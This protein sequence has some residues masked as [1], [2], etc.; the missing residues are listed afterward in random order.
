M[1]WVVEPPL[2]C[3]PAA[4]LVARLSGARAW[5]HVQ[6]FEVDAAF[7][8][9]LLSS[10]G[11]Y[12]L[13]A[14]IERCL[15]SRFD[16]VSTISDK[17]LERLSRKGVGKGILFPN[18]VD[19]DQIFPMQDVGSLRR[20]LGVHDHAVVAL[21]AGNMGRKQGLEIVVEAARLLA[22]RADL[23]FIL[24]GE[25]AA[26]AE[27]VRLADGMANVTFLPLQPVERLND[28]LNMADIHLLPQDNSASDLVMPS[29]LTG[30]LASGRP[31]VA[32]AAPG[33]QIA[34]VVQRCGKVV[35][36]GDARAFADAIIALAGSGEEA[37]RL[38]AAGRAYAVKM[39]GREAVLYRFESM[40][41]ALTATGRADD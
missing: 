5:L 17:M 41:H 10:R 1:V 38:G 21:Y 3:A 2:F 8:L 31:V 25:G 30:M 18:W 23:R 14:G 33:T 7:E 6:D 34:E 36:P 16:S 35:P 11:L 27:L 40:L 22:D 39:W 20:E 28:L 26:K 24:C 13:A 32:N 4:L 37:R 19:T 29:K 12:K 9:G 15:M